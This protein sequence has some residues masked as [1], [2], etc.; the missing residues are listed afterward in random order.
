LL[1]L[2]VYMPEYTIHLLKIFYIY[3][4]LNVPNCFLSYLMAKLQVISHNPTAQNHLKRHREYLFQINI[5]LND[6][7]DLLILI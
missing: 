1:L 5:R 6:V 4:V 2:L 3:L 7:I